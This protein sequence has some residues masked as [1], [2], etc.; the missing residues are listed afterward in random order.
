[1]LQKRDAG[2]IYPLDNA[3]WGCEHGCEALGEGQAFELQ[4]FYRAP[5]FI[6][7]RAW[8]YTPPARLP[9]LAFGE[10]LG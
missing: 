9:V 2:D 10:H 5:H 8:F 3:V 4:G 6:N 1:M 7:N